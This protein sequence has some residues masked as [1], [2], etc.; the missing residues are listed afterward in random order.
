MNAFCSRDA[1][2]GSG[3]FSKKGL[4][5]LAPAHFRLSSARLVREEYISKAVTVGLTAAAI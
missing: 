4:R 1:G 5:R 2:G 3:L